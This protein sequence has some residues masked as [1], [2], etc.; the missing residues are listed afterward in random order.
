MLSGS[1]K[2]FLRIVALLPLLRTHY[3]INCNVKCNN[4]GSFLCFAN[5]CAHKLLANTRQ[6]F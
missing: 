4:W 1:G 3:V 2:S 5:V 6:K